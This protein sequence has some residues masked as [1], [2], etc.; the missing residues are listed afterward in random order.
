MLQMWSET[1][2]MQV[3]ELI[4]EAEALAA[5]AMYRV[6]DLPWKAA[7][8]PESLGLPSAVSLPLCLGRLRDFR[9]RVWGLGDLGLS[10]SG[11][12]GSPSPPP[13][14][15]RSISSPGKVL[16]LVLSIS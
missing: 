12:Q 16:G 14:Q 13:S 1:V 11:S 10:L 6:G 3:S 5:E 15:K 8:A 9:F 4:R 2:P 7:V